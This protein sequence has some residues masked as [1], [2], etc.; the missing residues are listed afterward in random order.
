MKK[1]IVVPRLNVVMLFLCLIFPGHGILGIGAID[2]PNGENVPYRIPEI[3]T[4]IRVDGVLDDEGWKKALKLELNYEF[5]PGENIPPPVRTEVF[6]AF[7]RNHFYIGFRAYDPNPF[8]IRARLTDRDHIFDDDWVSISL[9]TFNAQRRYYTFFCNPL[10]IQSEAIETNTS[11]NTSWDTIWSSAGR[12]DDQGYIVEMAIPFNSLRFQRKKEEQVWG[13][14]VV[15]RYPRSLDHSI[16]FIP[17]DRNNFC[18]M[19]QMPKLAGFRGAKP[20]KSIEFDPTL[21]ALLTQEREDSTTSEWVKKVDRLDPG[22][23]AQWGF[24][25]N[26]TLS[27]TVNPDFSHVEADVAQLDINTQFA[28]Y[29]PEKR[30]F[31]LEGS[32]IFDTR[33]P[34][35]YTRTMAD[36]DWGI[37]LT[38]KEGAHAIG[39]YSARDNIT[40]LLFPGSY[41]S[42]S[43]SLDMKTM[44]T[45]LRYRLD[46]GK[47]STLGVLLTDREG[48]DYYNRLA[49]VDAF[50]RITPRKHITAQLLASQTRYPNQAAVDYN[51]PGDQFSGTALDFI[52]RHES[53]N[54][55][56]YAS[57]QQVTPD[58][59]AD[60]GFM[61]QVGYRN[62]TTGI[63]LASWRNPG[64]WYT[65]MNAMPTFEYEV[66]FDGKLIYKSLYL[67][68]NYLGPSQSYIMLN[69][70]LGKQSLL[71]NT[72]NTNYGEVYFRITPS[73]SLTLYTGG[74]FGQAIDF[75]NIRQGK[76][77]KLYPGLNVKMGRNF[78]FNLDH[79]FE[80]FHVDAGHLYTANVS[81]L[82]LVYQF[83]S[84][85]FL[86]VI[87][88]YSDYKYNTELYAFPIDPQ[89]R[90]LFSQVL[91]SY[92]INART[93]LFLGYSD[94][95]Y[96]LNE[97]FLKQ[98]NRTFFLK[99]GYALVL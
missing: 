23:T 9:D 8:A 95:Y 72:F 86:R 73:G 32:N 81:N 97:T 83:S 26:M 75:S 48:K 53:R 90:H 13:F 63:I 22:I 17:H 21:S 70:Q 62:I 85:A 93:V 61:P 60:L 45:V 67:T 96:N 94:D 80:W 40:N 27:G 2:T 36:P 79:I 20:G 7:S 42:A 68:C 16:G 55:G 35:I 6:L 5:S 34:A 24:T 43:T 10:G 15:R 33:L 30:P 19:C 58:F 59:R 49:G 41:G 31:F 50:L 12:L 98:Y 88:Q 65:F 44:G 28:L 52:F 82:R 66:D 91:F 89:S 54:I 38:G 69:G 77:F 47:I 51:Q 56:Y 78:S 29:Y 3:D 64:H 99:I 87:L 4:K 25:P 46:V 39:F 84:R 92:K 57:Y 76:R 11:Q 37:K 14:D 18:Y 71:G 1:M 74:V